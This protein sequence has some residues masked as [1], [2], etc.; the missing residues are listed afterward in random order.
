MACFND[1]YAQL[2]GTDFIVYV[3]VCPE[4]PFKRS[5][6]YKNLNG[7][8]GTLNS[9]AFTEL[10]VCTDDLPVI[11][12]AADLAC[13]IKAGSPSTV[14]WNT[15]DLAHGGIA[16]TAGSGNLF[17]FK[18][19]VLNR[20]DLP[21]T[22]NSVGDV[23]QVASE[24]YAEYVWIE[25]V[26]G[27]FEWD[28]LGSN[29]NGSVD[30]KNYYTKQEVEALI[31]EISE[32]KNGNVSALPTIVFIDK[33]TADTP[34]SIDLVAGTWYVAVTPFAGRLPN[35][36]ENGTVIQV[37]YEHG[38]ENMKVLPSGSDTI[39]GTPNPCLIG[40]SGDGTLVD[41][42]SHRFVYYS[43]NWILL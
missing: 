34:E 18:G 36:P 41:N 9:A 12:S 4:D 7:V 42:E 38:Q 40:I 25:N 24:D 35:A 16:A 29:G 33:G 28:L 39:N 20:A 3:V 15:I 2:T 22:G 14:I 26:N 30:L 21:S 6:A 17:S 8:S 5:I 23:Y 27:E 32:S 37:S 13:A 19:S 10:N 43:G 11:V 1:V 31:A